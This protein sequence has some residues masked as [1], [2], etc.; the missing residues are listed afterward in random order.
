[1]QCPI[2]GREMLED[3]NFCSHCGSRLRE[4]APLDLPLE[5]VCA[6]ISDTP[7]AEPEIYVPDE[8]TEEVPVRPWWQPLLGVLRKKYVLCGAVG[9]VALIALLSML[10][11]PKTPDNGFITQQHSYLITTLHD[12]PVLL[13]DGKVSYPELNGNDYIHSSGM[14]LDASVMIFYAKPSFS[15]SSSEQALYVAKG[16]KVK[17]VSS[18]VNYSAMSSD[19]SCIAYLNVGDDTLYTYDVSSGKRRT[20]ASTQKARGLAVSANGKYVASIQYE[21]SGSYAVLLHDG[22]TSVK[23]ASLDINQSLV[24]ISNDG[25]IVYTSDPFGGLFCHTSSFS[26]RL[27]GLSVYYFQLNADGS[28]I[29]FYSLQDSNTYISENGGDAEFLC[30]DLIELLYPDNAHKYNY[31]APVEDFYEHVYISSYKND[32]YYI[33]RDPA[34][35]GA[36]ITGIGKAALDLYAKNVYYIKDGHL[37]RLPVPNIQNQDGLAMQHILLAENIQAYTVAAKTGTVFYT[38]NGDVLSSCSAE[39]GSGKKVISNAPV[40]SPFYADHDGVFYFMR[41]GALY[42]VDGNK[43]PKLLLEAAGFQVMPCG[44]TYALTDDAFYLLD[45]TK[46]PKHLLTIASEPTIGR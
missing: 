21:G 2:C 33:S 45:G 37:Y 22:K 24:G 46:K 31:T 4:I 30:G 3:T 11:W 36:L 17:L 7:E 16:K 43:S 39:D 38:T 27:S 8:I 12:K 18:A 25:K 34:K 15:S 9:A 35:N 26:K 13:Y 29:I 5:F 40:V 6:D 41:D 20:F 42:A 23:L 28:Q 32:L 14:N 19:G 44:I 1:M 10:F